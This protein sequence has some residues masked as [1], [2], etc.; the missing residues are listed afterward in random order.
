MDK[1]KIRPLFPTTYKINSR[2]IKYV[3]IKGNKYGKTF[4]T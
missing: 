1:N 4:R 3:N 2:W